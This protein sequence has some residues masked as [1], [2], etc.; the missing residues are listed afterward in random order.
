MTKKQFRQN[1]PVLQRPVSPRIPTTAL[2]GLAHGNGLYVAVGGLY[3]LKYFIYPDPPQVKDRSGIILSSP[4]GIT[5]SRIF[6]TIPALW[7][8]AYGSGTFV[9]TGQAGTILTS[10]NGPSWTVEDSHTTSSL[11]GVTFANNQFVA[12]GENGTVITSPDGFTW[13]NHALESSALLYTVAYGNGAFLAAG[14][15]LVS[16]ANGVDW[17]KIKQQRPI[18]FWSVAFG[19]GRF[20]GVSTDGGLCCGTYTSDD[21]VTWVK[22]DRQFGFYVQSISYQAGRFVALGVPL[23]VSVD[24]LHWRVAEQPAA[25]ILGGIVYADGM[26]TAVGSSSDILQSAE[27][28]SALLGRPSWTNNGV[29]F[30]VSGL[31][32]NSYRVE[33]ATLGTNLDWR[34]I[35]TVKLNNAPVEFIDTQATN[36]SSRIYRAVRVTSEAQDSSR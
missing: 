25:A 30:L 6:A 8:V 34:A 28:G 16:S 21:G 9:A 32:E 2:T 18:H 33:A 4:D 1:H 14:E 24:G 15:Q 3:S 29:Q 11:Y 36:Y 27:S 35:G 5:W 26:W 13:Q 23:A 7:N 31:P 17:T 20:V 19:V 10:T 22:H 12:V